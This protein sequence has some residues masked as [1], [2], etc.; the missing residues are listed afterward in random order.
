MAFVSIIAP[1]YFEDVRLIV[2]P[3]ECSL[4]PQADIIFCTK[5]GRLS[6]PL[7]QLHQFFSLLERINDL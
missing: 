4:K 2:D 7:C 5:K 1:A 6:R 3:N